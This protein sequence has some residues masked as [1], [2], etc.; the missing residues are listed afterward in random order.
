[1]SGKADKGENMNAGLSAGNSA[2]KRIKRAKR[3]T[4]F[5]RRTRV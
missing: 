3:Q 4:V 1:M 2:G 5:A